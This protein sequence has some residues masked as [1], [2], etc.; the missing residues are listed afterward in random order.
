MRVRE[1]VLKA[2]SK[3]GFKVTMVANRYMH[4][5]SPL[6][7]VMT[8]TGDFDAA[9]DKIV[10]LVQAGDLVIT[11]DIPLADRVIE[12]GAVALNSYGVIYTKESIQ[13]K[14]AMRNLN[15]ELRSAGLIQGGRGGLNDK[16]IQKFANAFDRLVTKALLNKN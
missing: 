12:K 7:E 9:D 4:P 15:Q 11:S 2:S 10:E 1:I 5:P 6:V 8:V 13:E 14:L 3:K 16:D